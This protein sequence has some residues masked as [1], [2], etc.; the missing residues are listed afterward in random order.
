MAETLT[1]L[2]TGGIHGQLDLVPRLATFLWRLRAAVAGD[3]LLLDTGNACDETRPDCADSDGRA[4]VILLDAVGYHA[5]NVTGY[6]DAPARQR[7]H[8]NYLNAGLADADHAWISAGGMAYSVAPPSD[9]PHTL[10]I[11]LQ[12]GDASTVSPQPTLHTIHT[13]MLGAVTVGQV[14]VVTVRYDVAG[15]ELLSSRVEVMPPHTPPDATIAG[16]L[17]FIR[18]ELA[19]ARK[20]RG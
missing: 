11:A 5:L 3:V 9:R 7:L 2:Y 14:G 20:R 12:T 17:E 8:E 4:A 10:H 19:Y 16:T 15:A 6:I 18:D 13:V 1:I